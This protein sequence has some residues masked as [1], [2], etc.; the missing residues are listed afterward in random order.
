MF[1]FHFN[2]KL[3]CFFPEFTDLRKVFNKKIKKMEERFTLLGNTFV[4]SKADF[5]I[6]KQSACLKKDSTIQSRSIE[7]QT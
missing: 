4:V 7:E 1:F 6:S 5:S 2:K 3:L